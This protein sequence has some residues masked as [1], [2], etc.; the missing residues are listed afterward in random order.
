[1]H[2]NKTIILSNDDNQIIVTA[3]ELKLSQQSKSVELS[4]TATPIVF[5]KVDTN[6]LFGLHPKNRG[7]IL[8]G[9]FE[10]DKSFHLTLKLKD[11]FCTEF[12][13]F[14]ND[15][16][17]FKESIST[18]SSEITSTIFHSLD[19]W[20]ALSVTQELSLSNGLEDK[21]SVKFGF[22]TTW[23]EIAPTVAQENDY[24]VKL[25]NLLI[26]QDVEFEKYTDRNVWKIQ[27]NHTK[28]SWIC[29]IHIMPE[30]EMAMV[31]CHR[32]QPIPLESIT[33]IN[34]YI[35]RVNFGLVSGNC[36]INMD[37]GELHFKVSGPIGASLNF[38]ATIDFLLR[39]STHIY[40]KC[41]TDLE[42][43]LNGSVNPKKFLEAIENNDNA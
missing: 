2:L 30:V 38:E 25:D 18:L 19:S 33:I 23:S 31:L 1:M 42:Q 6:N 5:K 27:V 26:Q 3:N 4:I 11:S 41:L 28:E 35:A 29:H 10:D 43:L 20:N 9:V 7:P 17:F 36:G 15:E 39:Q 40:S 12:I 22:Q 32:P 8:G 13:D 21:G 14:T 34:E 16:S 24:S 37:T